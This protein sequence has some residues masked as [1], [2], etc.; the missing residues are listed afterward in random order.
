MT[1]PTWGTPWHGVFTEG[2]LRLPNGVTRPYPGVVLNTAQPNSFSGRTHRVRRPDW[3]DPVRTAEEF[4]QDELH[5]KQW[6]GE[7]MLCGLDLSIYGKAVNGWI[8][9]AADGSRWLIQHFNTSISGNINI[10]LRMRPFGRV[11]AAPDWVTRNLSVDA[12]QSPKLF[13]GLAALYSGVRSNASFTDEPLPTVRLWDMSSSGKRAVFRLSLPRA[14]FW[15]GTGAPPI[16]VGW[17]EVVVSGGDSTTAPSA[18]LAVLYSRNETLGSVES[19]ET[20]GLQT[21]E[22]GITYSYSDAPDTAPP[23]SITAAYPPSSGY[24]YVTR[25]SIALPVIGHEL[26]M[27]LKASGSSTSSGSLASR[28][29]GR[30]FAVWYDSAELPQPVML[31]IDWGTNLDAA[32]VAAATGNSVVKFVRN[33][34]GGQGFVYSSEDTTLVTAELSTV[35]VGYLE[36]RLRHGADVV[37]TRSE[38]RLTQQQLVTFASA[39]GWAYNPVDISVGLSGESHAFSGAGSGTATSEIAYPS[40]SPLPL[41]MPSETAADVRAYATWVDWAG[42]QINNGGAVNMWGQARQAPPTSGDVA[43]A[44]ALRLIPVAP[45]I[46]GW[47]TYGG[48]RSVGGTSWQVEQHEVLTPTGVDARTYSAGYG[49][50]A[51]SGWNLHASRDPLTGAV[52]RFYPRQVCYV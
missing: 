48:A 9:F 49:S 6:R 34:G 17:L 15:P 22:A 35:A 7:A 44:F 26:S 13:V 31:D 8:Y 1:V 43:G 52:A 5:G 51:S 3:E 4:A 45:H 18:S 39:T 50:W 21:V 37:T 41:A 46:A 42:W 32:H 33:P 25:T 38:C 16:A 11:G 10:V 40:L 28:L 19:V 2:S 29:V 14:N 27:P 36:C 47:I 23:A 24:S 30:I 20:D 12:L